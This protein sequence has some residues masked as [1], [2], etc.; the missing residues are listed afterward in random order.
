MPDA[1]SFA[2]VK[3]LV[4]YPPMPFVALE[5]ALDFATPND[6]NNPDR[7][8]RHPRIRSD[9]GESARGAACQHACPDYD[10]F[11]IAPPEPANAR[12]AIGSPPTAFGQTHTESRTVSETPC[13]HRQGLARSPTL[14]SF[15][16]QLKSDVRIGVFD[17]GRACAT[18]PLSFFPCIPAVV[19][20]AAAPLPHQP[21]HRARQMPSS[22]FLLNRPPARL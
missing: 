15:A 9:E 12:L 22:E 2:T 18:Q 17:T 19:R 13:S 8:W 1:F 11:M 20:D 5:I 3:A 4:R 7:H 16:T 14:L 21:A 10:V 6:P